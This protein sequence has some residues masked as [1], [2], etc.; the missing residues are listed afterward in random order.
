S[1][2]AD[3]AR[4]KA[5]LWVAWTT[6]ARPDELRNLKFSSIKFKPNYG[7]DIVLKGYKGERSI[8]CVES[9]PI[10]KNWLMQHPLK[11]QNNYPLWVTTLAGNGVSKL[12]GGAINNVFKSLAK[13]SKI[14][15]KH[16][17]TVYTVRK[18]RLTEWA[19][20][21]HITLHVLNQLAGW[22]VGST[23]SKH[24]IALAQRH[25]KSAILSSY[26]IEEVPTNGKKI[27]T[28]VYCNSI[29]PVS[30]YECDNCHKPL[31]ARGNQHSIYNDEI[32]EK[33]M[34]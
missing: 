15:K 24:Y 25:A 19:G 5:L 11:D 32:L 33:L 22:S 26:G 23:I 31:L 28:C 10:L 7:C 4:D 12:S 30:N 6:A 9:T 21:P 17:V 1:N 3:N 16:R 14:T 2:V 29:N 20:D 13:K 27:I 34:L 8:P 18:G